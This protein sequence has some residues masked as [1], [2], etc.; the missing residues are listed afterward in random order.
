M[1]A[2]NVHQ[3]NEVWARI[4]ETAEHNPDLGALRNSVDAI[5]DELAEMNA[6]DFVDG[7]WTLSDVAWTDWLSSGADRNF[8]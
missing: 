1:T 6:F 8:L 3:A 7:Q 4:N 2:G 5:R